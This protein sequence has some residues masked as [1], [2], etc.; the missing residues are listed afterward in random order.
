L[1][2]LERG[3]TVHLIADFLARDALRWSPAGIPILGATVHHRSTQIEAGIPRDVTLELSIRAAGPLA[4]Q[5]DRV[6]LGAS[7]AM[8]GFLSPRS[9]H[10]K[11]LILHL[12]QFEV[13]SAASIEL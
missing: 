7:L 13:A 6:A 12:T 10:G 5:L 11:G 3:N 1:I 9:R 4:E 8:R 2:P